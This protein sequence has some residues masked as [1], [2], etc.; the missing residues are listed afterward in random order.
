VQAKSIEKPT[1]SA[2]AASAEPRFAP[3]IRDGKKGRFRTPTIL[4][5]EATE[6]GAAALAMILARLGRWI[7]L[8]E[9]REACGVSRDGSKAANILRAARLH[10]LAAKGFRKNVAG[11]AA[12]PF[13]MII[14]WNANHFVVLEGMDFRTGRASINDPATGPRAV[15]AA[16]FEESFS[17]ICLIFARTASFEKLGNS[18]SLV[19][20]FRDRLRGSNGAMSFLI[21]VGLALVIPGLAVPL[22]SQVFVD[23][24]LMEGRRDW[25]PV[26]LIGLA[27]TAITR[28]VLAWLQGLYLA[29][30]AVKLAVAH[31]AALF[32]HIL[33]LPVN[34]FAQRY[35]GDIASRVESN[36]Q[37]AKLLAGEL[38]EAV[39]GLFSIV[40]F[41]AI[42]VL[43]DPLLAAV[44]I[45]LSLFNL[46][47]LRLLWRVQEDI[48]RR[49]VREQ[50]NLASVSVSGVSS[51]E[52]LKA[53]GGES[54]FFTKWAGVQANYLNAQQQIS[55]FSAILGVIP[56]VLAALTNVAILWLGGLSV[57]EGTMTVGMLVAFQSLVGSFGAPIRAVMGLGGSMNTVK[58]AMDRL[59]DVRRYPIESRLADSEGA[60][61]ALAEGPIYRL[62]GRIEL[63]D[64]VF[65]YSVREA[66]MLQGITLTIEPGQRIAFVGGSG[67]GKS[68]LAKLINGLYRPW[69]GSVTFD[70]R[71]MEEIPHQSF[72][73]SVACVDQEIFLFEGTVRENLTLWDARVPDASITRA[74]ADSELLEIIEQRPRR[75]DAEMHEGGANFSGGQRQRLEIARALVGDPSILVLDEATSALDPLVEKRIDENL[76]RRGCTCII[77]AHRLSTIRD[78]DEI[79][80]LDRG[81]IAQ[82]GTHETLMGQEGLYRRLLEAES[83]R[84]A[85]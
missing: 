19:R 52:Q 47:V 35:A 53:Q 71:T 48:S 15:P 75:Y 8:E 30:L 49:V 61:G 6:C 26:L 21:L 59:D 12:M 24:V 36:D 67:S 4:Q 37:V 27:A 44:A 54:D 18:P 23:E 34:F 60:S 57:M 41:G 83:S 3:N 16:E 62:S 69:S 9:M 84:H 79:I 76:R 17:G 81:T 65:G 45:A 73:G 1:V 42:M 20:G 39:T 77:V 72:A 40:F 29:R 66:P 25:V 14:F 56:G 78:A 7:P 33:R 5:M 82:R 63:R 31:G 51:I 50:S 10:G 46:V 58:G 64:V 55:F 85:S 43:Y 13:P 70:G 38:S 80:V 32:W 68:T 28:G 11:L 74:L 2:P 22:L